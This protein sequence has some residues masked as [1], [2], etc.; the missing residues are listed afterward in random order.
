MYCR[1]CG[2]LIADDSTYCRSCGT[3]VAITIPSNLIKEELK[4]QVV[5]DTSYG[6]KE[7]SSPLVLDTSTNK[8][9]DE[10][11][12]PIRYKVYPII[13]VIY[14]LIH[15][16]VYG[17]LV[18]ACESLGPILGFS[19]ASFIDGIIIIPFFMM[20]IKTLENVSSGRWRKLAI[21]GCNLIVDVSFLIVPI[22][23]PILV[24]KVRATR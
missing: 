1:I 16:F 4:K 10:H 5:S 22:F 21:W 14:S 13:L 9:T 2:S 3:K 24:R 18:M 8:S 12:I 7:I 19:L 11:P 17:L 15:I 6:N 20:A 23:I